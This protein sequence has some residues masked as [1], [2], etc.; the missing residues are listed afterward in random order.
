MK[1]DPVASLKAEVER[2]RF[3][4]LL[5]TTVVELVPGRAVVEM[6]LRPDHANLF[7]RVHGGAVFS[8]IDEAFEL[9][10]NSH[11]TIAVALS[12]SI[13]Y[14][15][16][17]GLEGILRAES[18]EIHRSRKTATYEIRVWDEKRMLIASCQA[19]AYRKEAV[20]PFLQDPPP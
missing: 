4:K 20:L 18:R 7:G 14:H 11:G 13:T 16:A 2:E 3:A 10:S 17:P 5:G 8:L 19:L 1:Q 15:N 12:M 6:R 9:S